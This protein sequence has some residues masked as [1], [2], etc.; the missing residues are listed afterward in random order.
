MRQLSF[1]NGA[2]QA[3]VIRKALDHYLAESRSPTPEAAPKAGKK[4]GGK[5]EKAPAPLSGIVGLAGDL[6][7]PEDLSSRHDFYLY[8]GDQ[9]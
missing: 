1:L 6:D 8:G 5:A 4:R 7:A 2:S 3:D 9:Y